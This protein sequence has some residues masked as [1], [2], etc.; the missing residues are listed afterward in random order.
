MTP[1]RRALAIVCAV[2]AVSACG[3]GK[4]AAPPAGGTDWPLYG[5]TSARSNSGPA[6]TG[7]TAANVAQLRRQ[8]MTL[9]GTVDSSPIY[10]HGVRVLGAPHDAFF[11]T[12]TYGK[13]EAIDAS[14]GRVLWRWTPPGYRSWAGSYRI[15][16]ATP[17]AD[18]SRAW[19]YA[20]SPDGRIQKLSVA[21]GRA[22]WRVRVTLLPTREKIPAALNYRRGRVIVATGGYIGD[23]PPYQGH[24]AIVD[25]RR[26]RLLRVWNSLCSNRHRLISPSSC[27]ASGSAI[28]A[29]SGAVA[30]PATGA[31][32]AA[33]GNG[34]WNG[35][36]NWGDSV[37]RLK[38]DASRL[39]GSWTPTDEAALAAQD[40]DLGSTAP[41][42]LGGGLAVQGGKDGKLRLLELGRLAPAGR[43]G[44]EVQT[45]A[46]PGSIDLF[47]TPAVWHSG[48]TTWIFVG[49]DAGLAAWTLSG[50]RLHRAW[51]NGSA[52]TSPVVAG[53]LLYAYDPGG[54]LRVYDPKTGRRLADL[55]AGRGHWNSPIVADGLVALPEGDAN[56]H[57]T[58]GVLNV[59]RLPS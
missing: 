56:D 17:A 19:I 39:L 24:V 18:P 44:G 7:I 32:L 46:T 40:A 35:R 22:A 15:T 11:V 55:Q 29:R 48:A 26:G 38:G 28:W 53:G 49:D 6:S 30:D 9:D 57:R 27:A 3:S 43:R 41:A 36:T 50:R 45:V 58:T 14:T 5:Y 33:T 10:L 2:V 23:A 16:T 13:T 20:A 12:T 34:D 59:Y 52:S 54:R 1:H 47:T 37:V 42:L 4:T 51:G 21:S 31:L 8:R 25:A